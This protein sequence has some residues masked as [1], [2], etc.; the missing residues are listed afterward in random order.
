[1]VERIAH[2]DFVLVQ[3]RLSSRKFFL[4][5]YKKK[6]QYH[7]WQW[8]CFENNHMWVQLLP[9]S[10]L[11]RSARIAQRQSVGLKILRCWFNSSSEH[12]SCVILVEEKPNGAAIDCNS[13]YS[14]FNSCL[15]QLQLFR[16]I[17]AISARWRKWQT[18]L[19]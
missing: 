6:G 1:M 16:K 7:N 17:R 10:L 15:L 18:R 11:Q 19:T 9:A 12:F 5:S 2:D 4:V 13:I 14:R 3:V 8:A